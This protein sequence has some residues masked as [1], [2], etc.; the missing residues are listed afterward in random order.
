[1]TGFLS[2]LG[3]TIVLGLLRFYRAVV[4]PAI[5]PA[6][7]FEPSCSVYAE[8]AVERFGLLRGATLAGHRLLR[9]NPLA[10]AGLD[11]VPDTSSEARGIT[12]R[13]G[14]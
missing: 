11:P 1:M 9:C 4:S 2:R 13:E 12:L 3:R 14:A 7:R 6:C 10:R 8:Q 5:G